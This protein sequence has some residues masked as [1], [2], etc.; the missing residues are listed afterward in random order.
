MLR[1]ELL[2]L[3]TEH[4]RPLCYWHIRYTSV[5]VWSV[6]SALSCIVR[7]VRYVGTYLVVTTFKKEPSTHLQKS[8][9][10]SYVIHSTKVDNKNTLLGH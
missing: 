6:L 1:T 7:F 4:I 5:W 3:R 10:S 2:H 8:I 9:E